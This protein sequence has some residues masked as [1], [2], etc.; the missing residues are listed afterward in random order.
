MSEDKSF[1]QNLGASFAGNIEKSSIDKLLSKDDIQRVKELVMKEKLS[2]SEMLELLNMCL[3]SESKL[4]NLSSRDRYIILK[5]FVWLREFFKV[6]ELLYDYKDYLDD[7]NVKLSSAGDRI[8]KNV[9]Q[10]F[11]HLAKFNVDLYLNII[12]TTLSLEG[13]AFDSI[14]NNK[15]EFVYPNANPMASPVDVG[16]GRGLPFVGGGR[17]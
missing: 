6:I 7:N 15:Y 5:Y 17:R 9:E 1:E 2:R 16:Q 11:Q 13:K 12:R 4:V 14:L 8:F 3:S 10:M